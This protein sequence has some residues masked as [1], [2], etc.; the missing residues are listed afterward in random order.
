[1]SLD[2]SPFNGSA[3]ILY[4]TLIKHFA[5]KDQDCHHWLGNGDREL[6]PE[7]YMLIN[8]HHFKKLYST[9]SQK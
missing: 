6:C 2:I 7:T 1:M 3:F 9:V 5:V 8:Y 4:C